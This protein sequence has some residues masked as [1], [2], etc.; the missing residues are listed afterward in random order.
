V[1]KYNNEEQISVKHVDC[2]SSPWISLRIL[3][4][5]AYVRLTVVL[6]NPIELFNQ[7]NYVQISFAHVDWE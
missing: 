7:D 3:V 1:F 6:I 4:I 5:F 2:S